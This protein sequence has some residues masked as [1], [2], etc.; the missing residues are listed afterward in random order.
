MPFAMLALDVVVGWCCW[1]LGHNLGHRWWHDEMRKGK[2]TF[3]AHGEREHHRIYDR[4]GD[5]AYHVA[6]DGNEAFISFPLPIIAPLA[7]VLV[8]SYGWFLRTWSDP[9]FFAVGLYGSM[10]LDHQLHKQFHRHDRLKGI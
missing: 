9:L 8:V 4:H 1:S 2:K 3:Y 5:R 10:L 6:E 7:V